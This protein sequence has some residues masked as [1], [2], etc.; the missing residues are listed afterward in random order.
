M[1]NKKSRLYKFVIIF[2]IIK[3]FFLLF[4]F[5]ETKRENKQK[6]KSYVT[7]FSFKLFK[8]KFFEKRIMLIYT[9]CMYIF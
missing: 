3:N 7:K 2:K 4:E 1:Q 6:N 5:N 8:L 9:L